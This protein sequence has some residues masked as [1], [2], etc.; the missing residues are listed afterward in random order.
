MKHLLNN[1]SEEEK[2]NIRKLHEGGMNLAIDNFKKLIET[3]SGDV[4]P[5][6]LEQEE[7]KMDRN[8]PEW[9]TLFNKLKD[10]Y[11]PKIITFMSYD[12]PSEPHQSLNWGQFARD[13][14]GEY[15]LSISS[16]SE[17]M[18]LSSTDKQFD[19]VLVDWWKEKGYKFDGYDMFE[20][21]FSNSQKIHDDL[22]SFFETF[23]PDKRTYEISK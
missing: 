9:K 13:N 1:L 12:D 14:N 16:G 5:Y 8:S 10:L 6:L 20:I 7:T 17:N 4:K 19:D 23:S 18:T 11:N 22:K 2:N 3:K 21:D 15:G